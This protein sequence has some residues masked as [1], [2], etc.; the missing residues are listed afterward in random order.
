MPEDFQHPKQESLIWGRATKK[1]IKRWQIIVII[2]LVT[3]IFSSFSIVGL[4][5]K[6]SANSSTQV[7]ASDSTESQQAFPIVKKVCTEWG[8]L[9]E[10]AKKSPLSMEEMSSSINLMRDISQNSKSP[11]LRSVTKQLADAINKSDIESFKK[12]TPTLNSICRSVQMSK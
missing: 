8:T 12:G 1:S 11:I 2:F 4:S 7:V 9:L 10:K 3:A 5:L 6:K